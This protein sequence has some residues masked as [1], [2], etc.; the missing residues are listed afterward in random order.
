MLRT[1]NLSG[2]LLLK[3]QKKKCWLCGKPMIVDKKQ[4]SKVRNC[5]RNCSKDHVF[6]KSVVGANT[7]NNVLFACA[8]CNSLKGDRMPT[9][10]E[11][12]RARHIF[13]AAIAAFVAVYK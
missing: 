1:I 8:K 2:S 11:G 10:E 9:K 12:M 13:L 4:K 6:P 7:K 3:I 5:K